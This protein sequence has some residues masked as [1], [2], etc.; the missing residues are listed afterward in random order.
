MN[1]EEKVCEICGSTEGIIE[2]EDGKVLCEDCAH[3]ENY[4]CCPI[5]GEWK[6]SGYIFGVYGRSRYEHEEYICE[7]C[8]ETDDKYFQCS[9]C[10]E[11][12]DTSWNSIVETSDGREICSC[13]FND[14]YVCCEDCGAVIHEDDAYYDED[15]ESYYCQDCGSK[16]KHIK[17][18]SYKPDPVCKKKENGKA[19]EFYYPAESEELLFGVENEIDWGERPHDCA[20]ALCDAH[21]DLYIKHDGSL[22]DE[23]LEIVTH[24]CTLEYHM[25][26]IGWDDICRIARSYDYKSHDTRCCGLHVHV[27]RYQLGSDDA[28]RNK[29]IAKIIMLVDR[30]WEQLKVF[31]RRRQG[32]LDE[33]AAAPNLN[34]KT[35]DI[36]EANAIARAIGGDGSRYR[37]VNLQ[38]RATI[39]FRLFNGTLKYTTIIA[40]LQLVS[41]ICT[42]AKDHSVQECLNSQWNEIVKWHCYRDLE[43]YCKERGLKEVEDKP[44]VWLIRENEIEIDEDAEIQ[45][46]DR[47]IVKNNNGS[48]YEP[49]FAGRLATVVAVDNVDHESFLLEFDD[50]FSDELHTAGGQVLSGKGYWM[51]RTDLSKVKEKVNKEPHVGARVEVIDVRLLDCQ[52]AV[53]YHQRGTVVRESPRTIL[54]NDL[55]IEFDERFSG[56]QHSDSGRLSSNRGYWVPRNSVRVI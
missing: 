23:G 14:H 21:S 31:S 33:W 42:Y 13:C 15:S 28:E 45:V 26:D 40:T 51:D 10:G 3:D 46:G 34:F 11:W 44:Y 37:A 19:V 41:N 49:I 17:N 53:F 25:D 48:W 24:P 43:L 39:E 55:L 1:T 36:T 54:G 5:C 20:A 12:Y 2:T 7:D 38:N 22:G 52:D 30:H 29:T 6:D 56:E 18:Y 27:G 4:E 50:R 47:V 35:G 9:D 16:R 32:Q 8:L